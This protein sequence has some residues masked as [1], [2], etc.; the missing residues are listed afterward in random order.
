MIAPFVVTESCLVV[1]QQDENENG[2][3][4]TQ[5]LLGVQQVHVKQN[6]KIE[7]GTLATTKSVD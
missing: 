6:I 2:V 4:K 3:M 5:T 7:H 1:W